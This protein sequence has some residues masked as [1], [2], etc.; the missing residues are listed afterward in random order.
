MAKDME[1]N[2]Y[3]TAATNCSQKPLSISELH[4]LMDKLPKATNY[5]TSLFLLG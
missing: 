5:D 4:E 2:T 3:S 1:I